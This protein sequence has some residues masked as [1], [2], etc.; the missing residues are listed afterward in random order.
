MSSLD[1]EVLAEK[2]AAIERH[3]ARV[4]AKTPPEPGVLL[5]MSDAS[6]AVIL[7]LRQAVQIAIDLV[8]AT[9][10]RRAAS[11]PA[12]YAEAFRALAGLG[13]LNAALAER[14][15]RAA[16]F[17][18]RIAHAYEGLDLQQVTEAARTGPA[19]LRAFLAALHA[20]AAGNPGS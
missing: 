5:P 18:D 12:T 8:V 17:R 14:L 2:V 10:V 11:A 20:S 1:A 3:L 7:H 9:A 15:A 16:S 13:L 19:D 6:D 4:E